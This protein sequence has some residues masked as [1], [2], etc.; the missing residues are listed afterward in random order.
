M[1]GLSVRINDEEPVVACA[2]DLAVLS[3]IVTGTGLLGRLSLPAHPSHGRHFHMQLG[4]L[5]SGLGS[6]EQRQLYWINSRALKMGDK[7]TIEI[8]E[9]DTGS[10]TAD[11]KHTEGNRYR[12]LRP[13]E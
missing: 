9:S 3:A 5:S 1:F 11:S 4:G 6:P 13:P 8:V 2:N 7:I 10:P 12:G